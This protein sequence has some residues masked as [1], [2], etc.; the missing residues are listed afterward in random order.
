M[1]VVNRTPLSCMEH[2]LFVNLPQNTINFKLSQVYEKCKGITTKPSIRHYL[3]SLR[4]KY[5]LNFNGN[6]HYSF[7]EGGMREFN[8]YERIQRSKPLIHFIIN[9]IIR[10][11]INLWKTNISNDD[12]IQ[13]AEPIF[14]LMI[15]NLLRTHISIWKKHLSTNMHEY[16]FHNNPLYM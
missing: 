8:L 13:R 15:I 14:H 10:N 6:G 1:S 4:K 7:T 16:T 5:L 3:Q 9:N 11:R 12:N 2:S